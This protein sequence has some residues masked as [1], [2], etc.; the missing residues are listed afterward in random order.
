MYRIRLRRLRPLRL[1]PILF[2]VAA[3]VFAGASTA[4]A[5]GEDAWD[6]VFLAGNKIG[7]IHTFIE[8]VSEKGRPL[9]RVRVDTVLS[10]RRGD[11]VVVQK[12]MY[13]T[14]ETPEGEVLRLDTRTLTSDNEI[15]VFGDAVNGQ[16][17][18]ILEGTKQRQEQV[19]PWGPE[20]RGPYA[21]EQSMAK[22]PMTEGESRTLK[23]YIPDL[24]RVVDIEMKA[25]PT[26]DVELGDGLKR[27]LRKIEQLATLDGKPRPELSAVL[28]VDA[29]GQVLKQDVD[30][31]G[32]MTTYRT[33][34]Q[35]AKAPGGRIKYDQIRGTIV[36]SEREIPTPYQTQYIKYLITHK[37]EDPAKIIPADRRQSIQATGDGKSATLIIQTMGPNDGEAGTA[38]VDPEFLRPNGMITSADARVKRLADR[39]V[40]EAVAPWD[41]AVRIN[42][43]VFQNMRSNFETTFAPASEAAQNLT[44]DCTEHSVLAAAMSRAKGIPSRVAVGLI[45][46]DSKE[47]KAKGFGF[48]MWHEV[49]V[50]NRWVALDSSF[51]QAQVDATHIKLSESS[52][53]GVSPFESFLPILRVQGKV[54]IEPLEL[55]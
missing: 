20:V 3:A 34:E 30:L 52:L 1:S 54:T 55:R 35:G 29:G 14:I 10:F 49:Y 21:A 17:K 13:G 22:K 23:M 15:R 42:H 36:K 31:L 5:R 28:W 39:A 51:D 40:A 7:Y 4:P 2:A 45:Y 47:L 33:T 6:A 32:G 43:W 11:D 46:V 16:M 53:E 24:N 9:N 25:G 41:Q 44:G 18:L 37:D 19:I 12:M 8:K 50:N 27:P 48:H 26:A 38:A